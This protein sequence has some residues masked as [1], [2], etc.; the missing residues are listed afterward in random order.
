MPMRAYLDTNLLMEFRDIREH[1]WEKFLGVDGVILVLTHVVFEELQTLKDKPGMPRKKRERAGELIRRFERELFPPAEE[2]PPATVPVRDHVELAYDGRSAPPEIFAQHSLDSAQL[3]ARLVAAAIAAK[4][5]GEEVC[6][7]SGDAGPRLLGRGLKLRVHEPPDE[8]RIP[9][10]PDEVEVEN[11]KLRRELE[12]YQKASPK[13]DLQLDAGGN[14]L[15]YTLP[16]PRPD[17]DEEFVKSYVEGLRAAHDLAESMSFKMEYLVGGVAAG[18]KARYERQ[19]EEFFANAALVIPK[20]IRYRNW[21]DLYIPIDLSI[22]NHG[23]KPAEAI[24]VDLEF[25]SLHSLHTEFPLKERPVLPAMPRRPRSITETIMGSQLQA[26]ALLTPSAIAFPREDFGLNRIA[27][28]IDGAFA[29]L[30][31]DNLRHTDTE[32]LPTLYVRLPDYDQ[33]RSFGIKYAVH[34]HNL[35]TPESGTI[36]VKIERGDNPSKLQLERDDDDDKDDD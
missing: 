35:P 18:E 3:D 17:D 9:S 20:A 14:I 8:W 12:T 27:W 5:S 36:H 21:L 2:T 25:P 7:V 34:A 1:A 19:L 22:A 10:E 26:H 4:A 23:S 30:E 33:A 16:K 31:I 11:R 24:R 15:R 29:S 13:L 6:L 32:D 28:E